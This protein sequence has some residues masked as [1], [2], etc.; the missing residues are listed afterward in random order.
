VAEN[1]DV[2]LDGAEQDTW[3]LALLLFALL[4]LAILLLAILL[5]AVLLL[6]FILLEVSSEILGDC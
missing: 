4:L 1:G 3:L 5:L 6:D 2:F